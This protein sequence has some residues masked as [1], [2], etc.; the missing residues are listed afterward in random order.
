M[1]EKKKQHFIP[2]FYLRLFANS[3]KK[4]TIFNVQENK[5][6]NNVF[7]DSQCQKDYF[8]GSDCV[9]EDKL[10]K[11]EAT[12][13][14]TFKKVISKSPLS[15][16]DIANIKEFALYQR[17]RTC[18]ESNHVNRTREE[19]TIQMGKNI[20]A[21]EGYYFGES[22]EKA[23]KTIAKNNELPPADSL[24]YAEICLSCIEDLSVL[25]IEYSTQ[26]NLISSDVPVVFI[27]PFHIHTIGLSCIGLIML[28]PISP[29]QLIVIYD[30][31]AYPRFNNQ[32]YITLNNETEVKKLNVLQLVSADK[33]LFSS[34]ANLFSVFTNEDYLC[35]SKNRDNNVVS[36]YG[37]QEKQL[38]TTTPRK[39]ILHHTFSFGKLISDFSSI[40]FTCR[41]AVP[42][43]LEEGW[44]QKLETK[45]EL[46]PDLINLEGGNKIGL[47]KKQ[48][49]RGCEKMLNLAKRYYWRK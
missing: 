41:E 1:P 25:I 46:F 13:S 49:K 45:I 26:T 3:D 35:R 10:A 47:T 18:G 24:N 40:P 43:Q 48:L 32:T 4:F 15:S 2:K 9:W 23:C 36:I 29:K 17:F 11:M 31:K 42:R 22:A 37:S 27:N 7:C 16:K 8:Y 34:D 19:M 30:S 5:I 12:W 33:I 14:S 44:E 6:V 38:V 20:Y 28:F 39:T 21:H